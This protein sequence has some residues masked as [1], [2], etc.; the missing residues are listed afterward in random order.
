MQYDLGHI[1]KIVVV[2]IALDGDRVEYH[3]MSLKQ[4]K[5]EID[6]V[7]RGERISDLDALIKTT[8]NRHPFLLHF[9]G[10]GILN[11]KAVLQENYHHSILLNGNLDAFYFSDY[12]EG[13][14]VYSSVIRKDVVDDYVRQFTDKKCQIISISSGPFHTAILNGVLN[15]ETLTIGNT[16]L[17][18]QENL[19]TD[20][21]KIKSEENERRSI[22]LG[23][24]NI[25]HKLIV[26]VAA[27]A[28]FFNPNEQLVHPV[29]DTI[30]TA[31][32]EEAK[33]KNIFARFGMGMMVFFLLLLL[34]N[35]LYLGHLNQVVLDNSVYL[36]AYDE[37]LTLIA[38]LEDEKGRKEKLL[39]S[40]GL[41]NK[42]FL[43]FYLMEIANSVPSEISFD[44]IVLRPLK[45]EIKQRKKIAFE[46]HLVM[47]NGRAQ[48]SHILSQWIEE[49][50]QKEWLSKVDI[51]SYDYE[52]NEG[53]FE[54]EMIVY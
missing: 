20:F 44:E 42:N 25:P 50:E 15:K 7:A 45:E 5:G 17:Q 3:Y 6:F 38:D 10:K 14:E 2:H 36:M 46:E 23:G 8:S 13:Q 22:T 32:N 19:L 31:N 11:R 21:T 4:A 33:Q 35:H 29:N 53:V 30:F 54:L 48:T 26:C 37:Q 52:K 40:S 49:I 12:I 16:Q 43:S 41:L 51:L 39:Q 18:F 1:S 9:T 47:V 27:G 28:A 34:A 24:E